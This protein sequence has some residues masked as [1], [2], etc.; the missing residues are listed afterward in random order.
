MNRQSVNHVLIPVGDSP[1]T[2]KRQAEFV[3]QLPNAWF[4]MEV[5][6]GH[7]YSDTGG[8]EL[9]PDENEAVSTACTFLDSVDLSY[10]RTPLFEP[11]AKGILDEADDRDVDLIVL[12]APTSSNI[13]S[14]LFST[15]PE[16]VIADTPIPVVV[17]PGKQ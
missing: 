8:S 9:P 16:S 7:A 13:S 2:A 5:T 6:V 4:D 1:E 15:V 11:V 10:S 12:G 3:A 14:K 17:V